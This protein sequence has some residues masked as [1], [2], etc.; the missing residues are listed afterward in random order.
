MK[1]YLQMRAK[2]QAITHSATFGR[3]V[4]AVSQSLPQCPETRGRGTPIQPPSPLERDEGRGAEE[5][6]DAP[7]FCFSRPPSSRHLPCHALLPAPHQMN[8]WKALGGGSQK[9]AVSVLHTQILHPPPH[10]PV[11]HFPKRPVTDVACERAQFL[12]HRP[13]VLSVGGGQRQWQE[14]GIDGEQE[15]ATVDRAHKGE[16]WGT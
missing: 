15:G 3:T 16:R 13:L 9:Y 4:P 11:A 7:H 8:A 2:G 14:R 10:A 6:P 5:E 1:E 12:M